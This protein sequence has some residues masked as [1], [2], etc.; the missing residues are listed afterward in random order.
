LLTYANPQISWMIL[1]CFALIWLFVASG[2]G[3]PPY[4]SSLS[5]RLPDHPLTGLSTDINDWAGCLLA[6]EGVEDIVVLPDQNVAYLKVD[7]RKMNDGTWMQ[8]SELVG[9]PV[10]P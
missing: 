2:L 4:L 10:A 1:S 5:I 3:S 6:V 8:L 7:K 9:H